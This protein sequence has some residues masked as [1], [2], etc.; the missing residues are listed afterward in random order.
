MDIFHVFQSV[1]IELHTI[2]HDVSLRKGG[3]LASGMSK[4]VE[5]SALGIVPKASHRILLDL[6][7]DNHAK[8]LS[9]FEEENLIAYGQGGIAKIK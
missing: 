1:Q 8:F 9:R 7:L 5:N 4:F 2:A 3:L 6:S